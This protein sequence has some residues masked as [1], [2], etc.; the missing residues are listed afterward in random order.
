MPLSI[1]YQSLAI[2]FKVKF[3]HSS[4]ARSTSESLWVQVSDGFTTG[5]GEGCPRDYVTG[6]NLKG[7]LEWIGSQLPTWKQKITTPQSLIEWIY[8]NEPVIDVNPAAWC[9][10][11]LAFWDFF[12]KS[13]GVSVE[14]LLGIPDRHKNFFYTAVL[15]DDEPAIFEQSFKKYL[16]MGFRDFKI[17]VG[18]TPTNT[19]DPAKLHQI[20]QILQAETHSGF[21]ANPL[22]KILNFFGPR[23]QVPSAGFRVRFDANN[24]FKTVH[25]VYSAFKNSPFPI[26]GLEEPVAARDSAGLSRIST[27]LDCPIILDESLTKLSDLEIYSQLPGKW[28]PNIR[29]SKM[30]GLLRSLRVLE[31]AHKRNWPVVIGAQVGETSLLSRAALS[32]A[33]KA[34]SLS[35]STLFAQEGA[36]GTFLLSRDVVKPEVRFGLAGRLRADSWTSQPGWGLGA[37]L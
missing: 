18:S 6:E 1:T 34:L 19:K 17:K 30:G 36:F 29:V 21:F 4:A 14:K 11:E 37:H 35:P 24:A 7:S 27:E 12:A 28:I 3:K 9:A 23:T 10:V 33:L 15:S 8:D 31:Y 32:V 5:Y 20:H 2:P 13:S 16:R 22:P 25:E 26:A